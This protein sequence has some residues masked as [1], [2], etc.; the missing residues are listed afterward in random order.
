MNVTQDLEIWT[1]VVNASIVV[2]FVMLLLLLNLLTGWTIIG[3]IVA[4]VWAVTK[5]PER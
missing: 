2:K 1:L 5:D 4:A 3:W